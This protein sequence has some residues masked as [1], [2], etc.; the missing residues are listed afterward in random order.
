MDKLTIIKIGGNVIDDEKKLSS[1]LAD[2][3]SLPGYKI[4]LH[5]G[6]KMATRLA[7]QLNIPQQ[8]VDGR[9]ITDADTLRIVT[10]VY[11]GYINKNIVAL[12]QSLGCNALGLSGADGNTVLAHKRIR[13]GTDFG[14]AGDIDCINYDFL[15][16]LLMQQFVPVIAPIT[17]DGKGQLLNTNADTMTAE[18]ARSLTAAFEV[19]I[20]YCFEKEGVLLDI[21]N[22]D[23][24]IAHLDAAYYSSLKNKGTIFA[25]MIPKLD[26]AFASIEGG[27]K[28][29][30]IGKAE[31]LHQLSKGEK[32]T[33]ISHG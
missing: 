20:I 23:S 33:T 5:G 19:D 26:N 14:F 4:L 7:E 13:S 10:M 16:N 30:V 11:A 29:V 18:M 25:G 21:E 31:S 9:R 22:P 27:V 6:G 3:A 2:F 32:G 8:M 12:L 15:Q 28:R 17:H 24:I 1:F